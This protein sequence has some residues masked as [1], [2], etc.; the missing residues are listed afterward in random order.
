MN[1]GELIAL[2]Q[3]LPPDMEV[4]LWNGMVQDYQEI[5]PT[6]EKLTMSKDTF[7]KW[8]KHVAFERKRTVASFNAQELEALRLQYEDLEF[9]DIYAGNLCQGYVHKAIAALHALPSGKRTFDR[10]GTI[11]Y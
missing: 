6:L 9:Q 3:T 4:K 10:L 1:A 11:E 8:I 2:L 7:D 5:D